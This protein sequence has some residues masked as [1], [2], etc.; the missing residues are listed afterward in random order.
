[1]NIPMGIRA[2]DIA[3]LLLWTC[4]KGSLDKDSSSTSTSMEGYSLD[5]VK[6]A[7][8]YRSESRPWIKQ[9][10]HKISIS[11]PQAIT[12]HG[13]IDYHKANNSRWNHCD[14][15]H[16]SIVSVRLYGV[17]K[18]HDSLKLFAPTRRIK[19]S[20][21]L[22][23]LRAWDDMVLSNGALTFGHFARW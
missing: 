4:G 22:G 2:R 16:H 18:T 14:S 8:W 19:F 1:M 17:C 15:W 3:A 13:S 5:V 21:P 12:N 20:E 23:L 10:R 6:Y 11:W 9:S 7:Y